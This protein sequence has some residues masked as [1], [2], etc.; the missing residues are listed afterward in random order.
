MD[1]SLIDASADLGANK[2][3]TFRRVIF[4]LSLPGV[5]SGVTLSVF[6]PSV[7]SFSYLNF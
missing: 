4:P 6:L 2:V 1:K 3:Q 7:S 5:I